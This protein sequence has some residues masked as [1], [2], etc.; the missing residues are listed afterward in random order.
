MRAIQ[1]DMLYVQPEWS[2]AALILETGEVL[3]GCGVGL[4]QSVIGELCFNTALTGYQEI[5]TDPSYAEQIITFTTP[6]IGNVGVNQLDVEHPR[7]ACKGA[8]FREKPT[9]ASNYRSEIDLEDWMVEQGL[10]GIWGV[11][12]RA[13]TSILRQGAL[14][15]SLVFK[16]EGAIDVSYAME[17]CRRWSG[18]EGTELSLTV[19]NEKLGEVDSHLDSRVWKKRSW[20]APEIRLE[21]KIHQSGSQQP[22][23][24]V[25]D[26]GVKDQILRCLSDYDCRVAV[27][28]PKSTLTDVLALQPHAI[29]LSN[30]PGDPFA[31]YEEYA[32][33]LLRKLL[34]QSKLPIFGICLGHQLLALAL[35]AQTTKMERGHRGANHPILNLQTGRVEIT[36]QNHGFVVTDLPEGV[37]ETH[38]SLFDGTI[39]GLKVKDRAVF[40]VQYHP[41]ASPGPHDSR[42]L[43][44]LF[45]A[46]AQAYQQKQNFDFEAHLPQPV[47]KSEIEP[48]RI[49]IVGAG[50]IVIGQACEFDYSGAQ[51]CKSLRSTGHYVILVNSN[52]ATIMTDPQLADRTYIEPLTVEYLREI[53]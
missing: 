44:E 28:S 17:Q 39:A 35:G 43:F 24:V 8:V 40:S 20:L 37:M 10:T 32:S 5:L 13:L 18:L 38:R 49:M 16:S 41:E 42:Y 33:T 52:P 12:T 1:T 7:A 25:I 48:R 23:V 3:W 22:L 6:H 27:V 53:E 36:S 47:I 15:A 46:S 21:Q 29:C 14:K 50:P 26:F 19:A 45:V 31:T 11:D 30:G 9:L 51:A 4:Q 2:D 34:D